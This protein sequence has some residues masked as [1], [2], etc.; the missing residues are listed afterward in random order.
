MRTKEEL[1]GLEEKCTADEQ[2]LNVTTLRNKKKTA[3]TW[4]IWSSRWS[5]CCSLKSDHSDL[6]EG[7][8]SGS[9]SQGRQTG[10]NGERVWCSYESK[11][12]V[13]GSNH[14]RGHERGTTVSTANCKTG[15]SAIVCIS[16]SG[17]DLAKI[18]GK[19]GKVWSKDLIDS[20]RQCGVISTA[21][22]TEIGINKVTTGFL[23]TTWYLNFSVFML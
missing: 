5:I 11:C 14:H 19:V 2:Y 18:N 17:A 23:N 20:R 4:H 10:R 12:D 15:S 6:R 21:D 16:A 13:F 1:S 8:L 3:K 7:R 22:V 9:Y